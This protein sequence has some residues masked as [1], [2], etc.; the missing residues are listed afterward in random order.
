[1]SDEKNV[2]TITIWRP[3]MSYEIQLFLIILLLAGIIAY[4][5][6]SIF[7]L[8]SNYYFVCKNCSSTFNV[9]KYRLFITL[10]F[11]SWQYLKCP[12]CGKRNWLYPK[13]K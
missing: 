9:D 11:F 2:F 13:K 12:I 10:H 8:S 5:C 3:M 6:Y 1:M 7:T 4:G